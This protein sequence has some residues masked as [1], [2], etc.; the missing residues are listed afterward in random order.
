MRI[1]TIPI[2]L[3]NNSLFTAINRY[4]IAF[5]GISDLEVKA[6][7]YDPAYGLWAVA[8]VKPTAA[9]AGP[10]PDGVVPFQ[11]LRLTRI[12]DGLLPPGERYAGTVWAPLVLAGRVSAKGGSIPVHFTYTFDGGPTNG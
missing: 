4:E 1:Q 10:P 7:H 8:F 2:P 5:V 11:V 3:V 6:M 9:D 12:V